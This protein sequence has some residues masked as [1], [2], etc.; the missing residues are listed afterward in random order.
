MSS[1]MKE[2]RMTANGSNISPAKPWRGTIYIYKQ[3]QFLRESLMEYVL[4]IPMISPHC[5]IKTQWY[6]LP[7]LQTARLSLHAI[8]EIWQLSS[9][10]IHSL[11]VVQP[12]INPCC[13]LL[14]FLYSVLFSLA[15]MRH[16]SFFHSAHISTLLMYAVALHCWLTNAKCLLHAQSFPSAQSYL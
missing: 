15:Q 1:K 2:F 14:M 8:L 13:L 4:K 10:T 7:T 9:T 11:A 3:V 16:K 5:K 12:W 6:D